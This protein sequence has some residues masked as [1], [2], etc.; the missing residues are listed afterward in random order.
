MQA[1]K[2]GF[3]AKSGYTHIGDL[4]PTSA[5]MSRIYF[6]R[7]SKLAVVFGMMFGTRVLA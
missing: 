1:Q 3:R 2:L 4:F 5:A 6:L 7:D